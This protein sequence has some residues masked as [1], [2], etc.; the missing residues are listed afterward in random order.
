VNCA[1]SWHCELEKLYSD[2]HTLTNG[3]SQ[4]V[5]ALIQLLDCVLSCHLGVNCPSSF[6]FMVELLLS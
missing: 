1:L 2:L 4:E 6:T 3:L 5:A